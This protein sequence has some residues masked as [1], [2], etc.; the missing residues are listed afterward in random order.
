[1]KIIVIGSGGRENILVEKLSNSYNSVYCIGEYINPDI[2]AATKEYFTCS[3]K[4]VQDLL[5]ICNIIKPDF[6]IIGPE[7]LLETNFVNECKLRDYPCIAPYKELAQLETS[8]V[9]TR[10]LLN[11]IVK[12]QYNPQFIYLH[13][14]KTQNEIKKT[15]T[16]FV[17]NNKVDIVIKVDG[18]AGGKGVFVQGDHFTTLDEGLNIIYDKLQDKNILI[19]E[20]LI[21]Q[22]FSLF[23]FSDGE[24][25]FH[26]PPIQDYKRA[27]NNN[28]GP[29]TGGMGSI[30]KPFDFLTEE[31]LNECKILNSDIL[32]AIRKKYD[33][34]YIGILYGSFMKTNKNTIKLIEYNCRFGDS[35]VFNILNVI[36]TDLSLIFSHMVEKTL[37]N[38]DVNISSKINIVKYLVPEGYP[39]EPI[40]KS[41][42]YNK[43]KNVY[44]A[45]IDENK[46]LLG[47]RAIAVYGE[48][49]TIEEAYNNCENSIS[50]INKDDL[51]W[52]TDI[53]SEKTI[54]YKSCGVDVKQGNHFVKTIK[55][56]VESTYNENVLGKHGNFGGQFKFKD[57]V[58]VASTD[59]VGT[60]GIL[61]K[62]YNNNYYSCGH[63]I[64]NHSI[65]D[66]LVQG[67]KPLFFLDYVASSKL[68]IE[69]TA[70]FVKGCCDAC[71]LVN[72]PL[73]GGETAEMP[74]VYNEGHLDMVGTIVGE[75]VLQI[76]EMN[77]ND[78]AISFSS[79][80][81]HTNGYTLI[82]KILE[83]NL[84]PSDILNTIL[85]P[86]RSYID[87]VFKIANANYLI[88][89]LCHITGGGLIEN[90][91]RTIPE[92]L[93]ID[94]TNIKYP[95]WCKWI[96]NRG[97]ISDEEMKTTF[98]CGIGFYVF[99]RGIIRNKPLNIAI[100]GSTKGTVMDYIIK[101]INDSGSLLHNKVKIVKV[102]SNKENSGILKRSEKYNI[103]HKYI[104]M[105]ESKEEYY[106]LIT[107]EFINDEI[108]Y[109]LCIGWMS[110]LPS[111]FI[112][113]WKNKCINVHPSLLPK[114]Q[115]LINMN[116][117]ERV[118]SSGDKETGCTVHIMTDNVDNGPIIVQKKCNVEENDT[119]EKLKERVQNLEGLSLIETLYYAYNDLLESNY[120]SLS[121]VRNIS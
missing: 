84:P 55:Q 46:F 7:T 8:K 106:N 58:L 64:V 69:D 25:Y 102:I 76:S 107:N 68:I 39:R 30:M 47:S 38:I 88:T 99:V 27:F 57:S 73:L 23:T 5:T 40:K 44:A 48:G 80:G 63:D 36:K 75:K 43:I 89:G 103:N 33:K 120:S 71:K 96:Q 18:L 52:R 94:L 70:S 67:A 110:I 74:T 3:F 17:D 90:L 28:E 22:E 49:D 15:I 13:N 109:I 119:P 12:M 9:F 115:K 116:V 79:S 21:G 53:G 37:N 78:I 111:T 82:R 6:I 92:H 29:N 93:E 31:D 121:I 83:K 104:K 95:E 66:I 112:N 20:K 42:S 11:T 98:N 41:I 26:L 62:K 105:T 50:E 32:N 114:Y 100:M 24:H 14:G 81:P 101:N 118:I 51:Y 113:K 54:T 59:G 72:C 1:M 35:E 45:S 65:N 86:H 16:S 117:H 56:D 19:E 87:D 10:Y 4:N 2:K 77:A 61:I 34:P 108:D 85:S 97:N 60:K 91:K